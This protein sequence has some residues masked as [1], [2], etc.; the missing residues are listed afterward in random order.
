M[1]KLAQIRKRDGSLELFQPQKILLAITKAVENT[2]ANPK[3]LAE[4]VVQTVTKL[5]STIIPT[6]QDV[7][8]IIEETLLKNK[9][10]TKS[11]LQYR[12]QHKVREF[13]T[14]LGVRD[15]LGLSDTTLRVLGEQ[16]LLRSD[17][18]TIAE[19]PVRLFRRVAKV[20][21][22]GDRAH[23]AKNLSKVEDR[24]FAM[25]S[26]LEFLPNE[27][28]LKNAGASNNLVSAI[29]LR[30]GDSLPE[31]FETLKQAALIQHA[32]THANI[33]FSH[34]RPKGDKV[35]H[36]V[37][38]GPMSFLRL[39]ETS[40]EVVKRAMHTA[41]LRID[42]PDILEFTA[43]SSQ[44]VLTDAFLKAVS[45]SSAY[46]LVN[47]KTHQLA[48][49]LQAKEVFDLI[50]LRIIHSSEPLL[51]LDE[52]VPLES[53][54]SGFL[55]V[56]LFVKN[57]K[58]EWERLAQAARDAVHFLDN[59]IDV[60]VYPSPES[61]AITKAHRRIGLG[62]M[63][64]A[65]MLI[66]LG[67][68]YDSPKAIEHAEKLMKFI[69]DEARKAS[70]ELA[71]RGSFPNFDAKDKKSKGTR[72]ASVTAIIPSAVTAIAGV[73]MLEPLSYAVKFADGLEVHPLF[74]EFAKKNGLTKADIVKV[75]QKGVLPKG[76]K[77]FVTKASA[78]HQLKLQAAFQKWCDGPV[79]FPITK[80][81]KT[82]DL[83]KLV[84]LAHSLKCRNMTFL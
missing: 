53:W 50:A 34:I 63:G 44:V 52:P 43:K 22:Q 38:S 40:T 10:S 33:S 74:A 46:H 4:S 58:P 55:N 39:F 12:G 26:K 79:T 42:H 56:S 62:V 27:T 61:E 49:S 84:L 30:V 6:T 82:E 16:Y 83:K 3:K 81:V 57:G 8:D 75:A 24:F 68:S 47:P 1:A 78:E 48:R 28:I 64:F 76:A 31:I 15:E 20:V 32:G 73:K 69:S 9:Q 19:T 80:P 54:F 23:D 45:T 41:S 2:K 21:A 11:L 66:K 71:K 59:A 36:G 70:N 13:R 35:K 7:Q 72:N 18:G 65:E 37:A 14:F 60:T 67:I 5:F 77:L 29:S 51:T 25:L 17:Q